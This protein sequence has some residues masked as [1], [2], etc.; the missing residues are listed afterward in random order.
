MMPVIRKKGIELAFYIF[1]FLLAYIIAALV[2]WFISLSQQADSMADFKERQLRFTIDS[3][4]HSQQFNQE[5]SRIH[6]EKKRNKTKYIAEGITFM[7][8]IMA[9]AAFGYRS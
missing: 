3:T 5:Y 7:L 8:V 4:A 6:S 1:W 2:W 9:G